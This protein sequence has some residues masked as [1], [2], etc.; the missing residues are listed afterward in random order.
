MTNR[1]LDIRLVRHP[2]FTTMLMWWMGARAEQARF[3]QLISLTEIWKREQQE[4]V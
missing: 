1:L 4:G 2:A 3:A